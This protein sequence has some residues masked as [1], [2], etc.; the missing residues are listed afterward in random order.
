MRF[1]DLCLTVTSLGAAA[2][3]AAALGWSAHG[4]PATGRAAMEHLPVMFEEV[5][6]TAP[7]EPDGLT[8]T[9][10]PVRETSL[11][12]ETL[13]LQATLTNHGDSDEVVQAIGHFDLSVERL[14]SPGPMGLGGYEFVAIAEATEPAPVVLSPG[15]S[16]SRT[17]TLDSAAPF[18]APGRYRV[19]G[20]WTGGGRRV[21]VE[22]FEIEIAD[23]QAIA[24]RN[25]ARR[26]PGA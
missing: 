2:F 11:R 14:S 23:S 6:I 4:Q 25:G 22:P 7:A 24:S 26:N 15:A 17:I 20:S 18:D 19:Q 9:L 12:G 8:A 13:A 5:V 21:E 16:I 10:S 3:L 1:N